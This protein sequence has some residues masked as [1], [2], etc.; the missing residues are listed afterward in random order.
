MSTI[1]RASAS[2]AEMQLAAAAWQATDPDHRAP[3][4]VETVRA[5][6]PTGTCVYRLFHATEDG[7]HVIAKRYRISAH[8]IDRVFYRD[9]L[10]YLPVSTLRFYGEM[11]ADGEYVWIFLED[12]GRQ[13]FSSRDADHRTLAARWLGAMH[14]AAPDLPIRRHLPERGLLHYR[15]HLE[16]GRRLIA[17]SLG[18]PGLRPRDVGLLRSIIELC[19]AV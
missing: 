13:Q 14:V 10:P 2:S 3:S 6:K 17:D 1:R 16:T 7:D 18:N 11:E 9:V 4:A 12:A 8:N 5:K 15:Q 19:D